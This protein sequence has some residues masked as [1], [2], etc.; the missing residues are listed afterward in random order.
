MWIA[1]GPAQGPCRGTPP[2]LPRACTGVAAGV[3]LAEGAL[4]K[5]GALVLGLTALTAT[6][7]TGCEED[8]VTGDEANITESVC[9]LKDARTG[10]QITKAALAELNDPIAQK[11]FA[12]GSCPTTF[13]ETIA[14]LRETDAKSCKKERDG[15]KTRLVAE[16]SQLIGEP[17][18]YRAVVSR[19]CDGRSD[20]ELLFSL[21]GISFDG[22]EPP[23]E[24]P[25]DV[26]IIA[27]DRERQ[28]FDYYT[29]ESGSWT[30]FGNSKD[31]LEPNASKKM[32]CA[33]CHTGGGLIMKE[34]NQPWVHWEGK[35][36]TAGTQALVD[37]FPEFGTK[38]TGYNLEPAIKK[39]NE[40]WNLERIEHNQEKK[41]VA[42]LVRPLFCSVEVNIQ[43]NGSTKMSAINSDFL[44]DPSLGRKDT[45]SISSTDYASLLVENNQRITDD[46]GKTL[47][48]KAGKNV[49]DTFFPFAY[50][51]RSGADIDYVAKLI[52][53]KV[54]TASFV[55]D[56]LMVD[57]TRPIFSDTRCKLADLAPK[58]AKTAAE[59][60]AGFVKALEAKKPA[61]GTAEAKLLANLKDTGDSAKH[62]KALDDFVK[63][64]K[65]RP[66]RDL[67]SDVLKVA[68]ARRDK[69][70]E[71]PIMEFA[72]S[73]PVDDLDAD[74]KN[75]LDPV[76][77]VLTTK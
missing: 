39:G 5:L 54:V 18:S 3:Q 42:D 64:C 65:A 46:S 70:R 77:C 22:T 21:F 40:A 10:K 52:E 11:I 75:A 61:A 41:T 23:S 35:T 71:R 28:V 26:E 69:I 49:V 25:E 53:S 14:K 44:F 9:K 37:A 67:L 50:P 4:M 20:H 13:Q 7:V 60:E 66:K 17:D 58:T 62:D 29:I 72:E 48:N 24:L 12:S 32:R 73:L 8:A 57:F 6:F 36:D 56:V 76:T 1:K 51:E 2:I 16:R 45:L 31:F 15:L 47:R 55:K 30:H 27:F 43:A 74:P 33:G 19:T 34:L 59:L 38:A 63:A 68:S